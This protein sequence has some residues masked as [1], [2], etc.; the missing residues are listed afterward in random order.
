MDRIAELS[1]V[2]EEE[3]K[4]LLHQ[5]EKS[6]LKQLN[7]LA[8]TLILSNYSLK[9]HNILEWKIRSVTVDRNSRSEIPLWVSV[10]VQFAEL[11]G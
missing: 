1:I 7:K 10:F 8:N 11:S 5:N 3:Y 4:L 9:Y 6:H 2:D